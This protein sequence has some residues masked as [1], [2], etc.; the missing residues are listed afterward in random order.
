MV[1][2][3]V[4]L[5]MVCLKSLLFN[6][7]EVNCCGVKSCVVSL[8]RLILFVWRLGEHGKMKIL[9]STKAMANPFA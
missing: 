4:V 3:F 6:M 1:H 7:C 2:S 9:C 8:C 5:S